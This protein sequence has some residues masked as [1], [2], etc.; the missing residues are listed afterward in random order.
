MSPC[1]RKCSRHKCPHVQSFPRGC[2]SRINRQR[3]GTAGSDGAE[4]QGWGC[5][6]LLAAKRGP[7]RARHPA[8]PLQRGLSWRH[9]AVPGLCMSSSVWC[10]PTLGV[11][12]AFSAGAIVQKSIHPAVLRWPL[13]WCKPGLVPL[14]QMMQSSWK[15]DEDV[16]E[17]EEV[18]QCV[19]DT[20]NAEKRKFVSP[21]LP[22]WVCWFTVWLQALFAC[23]WNT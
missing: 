15:W 10:S 2:L 12:G 3:F 6:S 13:L 9:R 16:D 14:R 19:E 23:L 22:C 11:S 21:S 17:V 20:N 5:R 4:L 7:T 1:S 18:G 8:V